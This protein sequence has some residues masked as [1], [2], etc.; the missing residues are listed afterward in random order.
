MQVGPVINFLILVFITFLELS[1]LCAMRFLIA[2]AASMRASSDLDISK[3][4]FSCAGVRYSF[5]R[6]FITEVSLNVMFQLVGS[7]ST[8]NCA[9]FMCSGPAN[10]V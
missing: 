7:R 1:L 6:T 3:K 9:E 2:C 10:V 4:P 5:A 8:L